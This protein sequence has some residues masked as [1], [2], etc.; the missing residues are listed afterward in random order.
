MKKLIGL[1]AVVSGAAFVLALGCGAEDDK[2]AEDAANATNLEG[3]WTNACEEE[4]SD[5]T[6][7]TMLFRGMLDDAAKSYSKTT[8]TFTGGNLKVQGGSYSDAA[9]ATNVLLF[10][11]EGTYK[12][13]GTEA[14][15]TTVA[16]A[17][18]ID[19]LVTKATMTF[20][21]QTTVDGINA[22]TGC[23]ET[24]VKGTAIDMSKCPTFTSEGGPTVGKTWYNIYS[25]TATDLKFGKEDKTNNG[26][27]AALRPTALE[28]NA[29]KKG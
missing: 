13:T 7:T 11:F 2:K 22:A 24:V 15:G 6:T 19:F 21:D 4:K 29:M 16:A 18:P 3:A 17:S 14:P 26:T 5:S 9:C 27:T 20:N 28:T 1:Y 12:T 23:T 10:V 25:A 8:A